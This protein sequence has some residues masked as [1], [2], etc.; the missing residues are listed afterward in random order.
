LAGRP[1]DATAMREQFE[2]KC[3]PHYSIQALVS[4]QLPMGLPQEQRDLWL[5]GYR[6]AG[7]NV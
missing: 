1:D 2:S 4:V 3:P 5:E 7:F 6:K